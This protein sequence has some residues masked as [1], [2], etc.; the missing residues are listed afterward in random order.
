MLRSF[1]ATYTSSS[2]QIGNTGNPD[3]YMAQF[4]SFSIPIILERQIPADR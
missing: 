2:S 4:Q 1:P 3:R